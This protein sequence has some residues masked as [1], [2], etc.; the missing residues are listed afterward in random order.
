MADIVINGATYKDV[1]SIQVP[2][3]NGEMVEFEETSEIDKILNRTIT[4]YSNDRITALGNY[5]FCQCKQLK[6]IDLYNVQSIGKYSLCNCY[7]LKTID[8]HNVQS[9]DEYSL[10]NC[11]ALETIDLHNVQSIERYGIY[12]CSVLIALI[13]RSTN[14]CTLTSDTG[15][16]ATGISS[17]KGYI[18]VPK[19]LVDSY[20]T[21]TNWSVYANQIRALEDYTVDGTITGE[22]DESKI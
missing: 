13:M 6:A 17:K 8:L 10:C 20:K 3:E 2:D 7:A 12:G 9:I 15:M 22:L 5:T 18:Y 14:L 21:A 1:P 19:A 16:S 11:Y 4:S